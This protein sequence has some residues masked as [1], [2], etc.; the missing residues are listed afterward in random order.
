LINLQYIQDDGKSKNKNQTDSK[1]KPWCFE[2]S[3]WEWIAQSVKMQ[4]VT[5]RIS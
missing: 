5:L 2:F 3:D 4:A 1:T